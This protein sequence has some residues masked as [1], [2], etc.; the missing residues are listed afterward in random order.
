LNDLSKKFRNTY[1][2]YCTYAPKNANK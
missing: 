2:F 1:F